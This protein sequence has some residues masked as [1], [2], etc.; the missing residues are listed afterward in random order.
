MAPPLARPL[1]K[2]LGKSLIS[3]P[4]SCNQ[5]RDALTQ[6]FGPRPPS[7]SVDDRTAVR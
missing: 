3:H 7:V 1:Y 2:R 5:F 4:R 6:K